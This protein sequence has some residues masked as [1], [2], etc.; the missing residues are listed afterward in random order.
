MDFTNPKLSD[1]LARVLTATDRAR[2]LRTASHMGAYAVP[3]CTQVHGTEPFRAI[4]KWEVDPHRADQPGLLQ[5]VRKLHDDAP[6][7]LSRL[8]H[9]FEGVTKFPGR[10][11]IAQSDSACA[12][13]DRICNEVALAANVG[14]HAI[15]DRH[16]QVQLDDLVAVHRH[17]SLTL[18]H[19][20]VRVIVGPLLTAQWVL[21]NEHIAAI[22]ACPGVWKLSLRYCDLRTDRLN[23]LLARVNTELPLAGARKC[24]DL[25]LELKSCTCSDDDTLLLTGRIPRLEMDAYPGRVKMTSAVRIPYKAFESFSTMTIVQLPPNLVTIQGLAFGGCSALHTVNFMDCPGLT[26][27]DTAAFQ[28]CSALASIKLPPFVRVIKWHAFHG[29]INLKNVDLSECVHLGR[30][31]GLDPDAFHQC[32]ADL[33]VLMHEETEQLDNELG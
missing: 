7:C 25:I 33:V 3:E 24:R 26:V 9:P 21:S 31:N 18:R 23:Q 17:N 13:F 32:H 5:A 4:A 6:R 14:P 10:S 16:Q 12:A 2:L 20:S 15:P 11:G 8:M 30:G 27:I 29:C 1:A 19:V 22:A 28:G